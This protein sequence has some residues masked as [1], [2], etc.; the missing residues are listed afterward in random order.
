MAGSS[1]QFSSLRK[2]ALVILRPF[3]V[4]IPI[5]FSQSHD[6]ASAEVC[7]K[8]DSARFLNGDRYNRHRMHS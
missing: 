5:G 2:T 3:A 4:V 1:V 7:A 8:Q 6:I